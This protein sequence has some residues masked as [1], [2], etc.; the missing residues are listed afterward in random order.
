MSYEYMNYASANQDSKTLTLLA[1]SW[2]LGMASSLKPPTQGI[3][4]ALW[5]G[6]RF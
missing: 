2:H 3:P 5:P 1:W 6:P 4:V